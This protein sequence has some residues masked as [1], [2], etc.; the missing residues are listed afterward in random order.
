MSRR[1]ALKELGLK[2]G[3]SA[4]EI[5]SRRN[6]LIK[7]ARAE[8]DFETAQDIEAAFKTLRET[9]APA[10]HFVAYDGFEKPPEKQEAPKSFQRIPPYEEPLIRERIAA[11][12]D[13]VLMKCS[14]TG[15]QY[16][17]QFVF[18]KLTNKYHFKNPLPQAVGTPFADMVL[19]V[20]PEDLTEGTTVNV[21]DATELRGRVDQH[22]IANA[23]S[24]EIGLVN[25]AY[26]VKTTMDGFKKYDHRNDAEFGHNHACCQCGMR[27]YVQCSKC[28]NYTCSNLEQP[29]SD[30]PKQWSHITED[31]SVPCPHC[32]EGAI[33][34]SNPRKFAELLAKRQ[35]EG[36]S[37]TDHLD[38]R[39]K[40]FG[41][42][43]PQ[44]EAK[45]AHRG[46]SNQQSIGQEK[47]RA[48]A[49]NPVKRIGHG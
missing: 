32:N 36:A 41:T 43:T 11:L 37:D 34:F 13:R 38:Q 42:V 44:T 1:L 16:S 40:I 21:Q 9:T 5:K 3:A 29:Y 35:A 12:P 20:I 30:W 47:R 45:I 4:Q 18:D 33:N 31:H 26:S 46:T 23:A 7:K 24:K 17:V 14:V 19:P 6:R 22:F 27:T 39:K 49:H 8:G 25:K 10:E 2:E 48:I 15:H 28:G